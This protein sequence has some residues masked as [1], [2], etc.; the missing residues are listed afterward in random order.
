MKKA[1]AIITLIITFFIIYFLQSNFFTWFNINGIMPNLFVIFIL[2][3]GLFIGKKVGSILGIVFGLF[4]DIVLGNSGFITAIILG[5]IGLIA[6]YLE[7]N[8]SKDSRITLILII[9]S[10]TAFY[11]IIF[12]TF[13]ILTTSASLEILNFIKILSIEIVFN[14]LITI[15]V[16]PVIQKVGN[17]L[18]SLFKNKNIMLKYF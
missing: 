13:K 2:F 9:A 18:E 3:I 4:L 16:H 15:I 6:E 1:L 8:F 10:G 14:I 5:I 17:K 7:K 12:Y 11:E